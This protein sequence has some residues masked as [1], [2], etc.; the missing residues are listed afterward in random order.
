MIKAI[1]LVSGGLD[2]ALATTMIHSLGIEVI[3]VNFIIPFGCGQKDTKGESCYFKDR[4]K[5]AYKEVDISKDF[6]ELVKSPAHGYGSHMNPCIDCK[7]FMLKKAKEMMLELGASFLVTGEV[8]GQRPMSQKRETLSL[9]ERRADVEG[10]VLRPLSAQL[11]PQTLAEEKGWIKRS[12][13]LDISGRSRKSQMRLALDFNIGAYENPAGGC[14]LTDPCFSKRVK[15]LMSH[16]ELTSENLK[17][18]KSGRMFRLN[19]QA[20]L[21]I[22]RDEKNN[23]ALMSLIEKDDIFFSPSEEIAGASALGRGIFS[24]SDIVFSAQMT[25]RYFDK[26]RGQEKVQVVV[27][28]NGSRQI[29]E[30]AP[31]KDEETKKY[32]I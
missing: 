30:V 5:V 13:L 23:S 10:L 28:R 7:I 24:D 19:D 12:D 8:V 11:L 26:K 25:A 16:N 29:L 18:L 15:D 22:G 21:I 14:L 32:L 3:A 1:S 2:S 31:L 9:I 27:I 20:K 17:L 4:L 6:I